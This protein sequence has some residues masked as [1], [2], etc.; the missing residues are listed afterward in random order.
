MLEQT[1][2]R[3]RLSE[4]IDGT[5]RIKSEIKIAQV[6]SR[7]CIGGTPIAV[8]LATEFLLGRGYPIVLLTGRVTN[9]KPVSKILQFGRESIRSAF[10]AFPSE[11]RYGMTLDRCGN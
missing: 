5:V 8:I 2:D 7:L 3:A 11:I 10:E 9:D 6:I 4:G 1:L